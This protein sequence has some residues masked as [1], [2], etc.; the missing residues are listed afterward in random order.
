MFSVPTP[1]NM[2]QYLKLEAD[3]YRA[4]TKGDW[5]EAHRLALMAVDLCPTQATLTGLKA[6][7]DD[8]TTHLPRKLGIFKQTWG[9]KGQETAKES[10]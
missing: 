9:Q 7:I 2:E 6:E 5:P 4:K 3:M 8:I 1:Q 10:A